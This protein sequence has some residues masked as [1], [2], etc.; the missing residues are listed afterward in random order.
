MT[1]TAAPPRAPPLTTMPSTPGPEFPGGYPRNSV[2]FGTNQWDHSTSAPKEQSGNGGLFATAKTYLAAPTAYLPPAVASYFPVQSDAS[3]NT[4]STASST[5]TGSPG[6]TPVV[7]LPTDS[8]TF[9]THAQGGRG[10]SRG[11]SATS[12]PLPTPGEQRVTFDSQPPT[13]IPDTVPDVADP[14]PASKPL[15]PA[16]VVNSPPASKAADPGVVPLPSVAPFSSVLTSTGRTAPILN[17]NST[18]DPS[19]TPNPPVAALPPTS[20]TSISSASTPS[21]YSTTSAS[22]STAPSSPASPHTKFATMPAPH[23]HSSFSASVKRFASM[24]RR[25]KGTSAPPS[26]FA[27][28]GV[29]QEAHVRGAS[30][31]SSAPSLSLAGSPSVVG[32]SPLSANATD[33]SVNG[34]DSSPKPTHSRRSSFLRTLRGEATLIAGKVRGDKERVERG[35]RMVTGQV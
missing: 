31:D 21:A 4:S 13:I 17:S 2:V 11:S 33:T 8:S 12:T 22:P 35:R 26:A 19:S 28:A 30:L 16:P 20:P 27:G 29:E 18:S 1:S 25:E 24:R 23:S 34:S 10:S 3:N 32:A 14:A 6:H 7:G 9:S 15:P 5:P